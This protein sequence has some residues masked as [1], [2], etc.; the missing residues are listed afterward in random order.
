MDDIECDTG[1]KS[2]EMDENNELS[3]TEC[4]DDELECET[5][6]VIFK[7][8]LNNSCEFAECVEGQGN[9]VNGLWLLPMCVMT[10]LIINVVM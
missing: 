10:L 1:C 2:C 7:R 9:D 5:E 3:C 6:G 8:V 4:M